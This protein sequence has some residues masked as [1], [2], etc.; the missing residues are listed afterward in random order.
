MLTLQIAAGIVLAALVLKYPKR[1]LWAGAALGVIAV[2]WAVLAV[3]GWTLVERVVGAVLGVVLA[4]LM[5]MLVG[6]AAPLTNFRNRVNAFRV[7]NP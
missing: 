2:A 1:A 3:Y 6:P 7:R 5:L 4:G